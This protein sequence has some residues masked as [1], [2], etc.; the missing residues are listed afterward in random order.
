MSGLDGAGVSR[1]IDRVW[2]LVSEG[3]QITDVDS[4]DLF[5]GIRMERSGQSL[6]LL[7]TRE[8]FALL[9]PNAEV[10]PSPL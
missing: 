8:D 1:G 6:T 2:R 9:F 7:L 3:Y 5:V 10:P 4:D